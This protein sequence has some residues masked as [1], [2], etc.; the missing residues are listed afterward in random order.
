MSLRKIQDFYSTLQI[1]IFMFLNRG[2]AQ[3]PIVM[4]RNFHTRNVIE[5]LNF[6][7]RY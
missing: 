3:Y 6:Q 7:G 5:V 4:L 1:K 2:F